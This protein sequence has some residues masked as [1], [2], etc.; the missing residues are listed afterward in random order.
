MSSDTR[1]EPTS[2]EA[3]TS[4]GLLRKDAEYCSFGDTVHYANPPKIFNR[5]EGSYLF[6]NKN[7]IEMVALLA[8]MTTRSG[9]WAGRLTSR[10]P[11]SRAYR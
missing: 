1:L 10:P 4:A 8:L 7:V 6:V 3:E 2:T 5:C 9:K 11:A